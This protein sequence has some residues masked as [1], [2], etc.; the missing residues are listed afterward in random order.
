[1]GQDVILAVDGGN[2][3]TDA[4]LVS[5]R[6]GLLGAAHGAGIPYARI[7]FD[8]ALRELAA[9]V[10][11]CRRAAGLSSDGALVGTGVYC[12]PGADRPRN[13]RV[14]AGALAVAGWTDRVLLRNDTV[15]ALRAGTDRGWGIA[16]V[17][18][19]GMNC[20]GVG[21]TGRTVRFPSLGWIS[22]DLG[23]GLGVGREALAAAVRG[24]DGRG[25]RTALERLVPEHFG[26]ARPGAIVAAIE[27][28]RIARGR[29]VELP[30]VVVAA[31]RDGDAVAAS[32]LER[33]AD[34][35]VALAV[36]A[37]RRLRVARSDV[38]V[39]LAGGFFRGGEDGFLTGVRAGI[40][41]RLSR[42][43]LIPLTAPP[44]LGAALLGL[45]ALGA[46]GTAAARLRAEGEALAAL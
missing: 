46:D 24:R 5:E 31:A 38:D 32:I 15:A 6:G 22:G 8:A 40:E 21:P 16:V 3:K 27:A 25:P 41:A 19:A 12:L 30:P 17:C 35:V 33:M 11:A 44:V 4:V 1:M 14:L 18:G 20:F 28:G 42:A 45:D 36:A 2:S 37:A 9:T 34:E 10:S 13:R 7:G 43:R 23:G 39:V 26:L 29:V